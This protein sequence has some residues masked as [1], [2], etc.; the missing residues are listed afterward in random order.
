MAKEEGL[1]EFQIDGGILKVE[2]PYVGDTNVTISSY[3][4]RQTYRKTDAM[5]L[6]KLIKDITLTQNSLIRIMGSYSTKM[7]N[8]LILSKKMVSCI[9]G[10]PSKVFYN[11]SYSLEDA[12]SNDMLSYIPYTFNY[13]NSNIED[14]ENKLYLDN[15]LIIN[16]KLYFNIY[17]DEDVLITG[18]GIHLDQKSLITNS[19]QPFSDGKDYLKIVITDSYNYRQALTR[20]TS[21]FKGDFIFLTVNKSFKKLNIALYKEDTSLLLNK[22]NLLKM[23]DI[24]FRYNDSDLYVEIKNKYEFERKIINQRNDLKRT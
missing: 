24:H 1:H 15:F 3:K 8:N 16:G 11:E 4:W 17:L 14:T 18:E 19:V 12:I 23:E 2:P 6:T 21:N 10:R 20:I 5:E 7:F 22:E 13:L 9:E